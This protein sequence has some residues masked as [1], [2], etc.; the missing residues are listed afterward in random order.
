MEKI[1]NEKDHIFY[2]SPGESDGRGIGKVRNIYRIL[3]GKSEGKRPIG[4]LRR[5][6]EDNINIDAL[7]V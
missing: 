3:V 1:Y 6:R 4:K 5:R 7:N 2:T